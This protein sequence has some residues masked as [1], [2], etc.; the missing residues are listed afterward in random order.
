MEINRFVVTLVTLAVVPTGLDAASPAPLWDRL[1]P[2]PHAVGFRVLWKYDYARTWTSTHDGE[3]QPTAD[4]PYRPVRISIWY[5]AKIPGHASPM[6]FSGYVNVPVENRS[7]A[8]LNQRLKEYDLGGNGKGLRG[9][10]KSP[11]LLEALLDTPT[12]AFLNAPADSGSFPLVVYSLG[13]NDYTQENV[14]LWEYLASHG[15]VVATV[16][17]LGTSPRR[18]HLFIDD[19]RSY[20][21]QI[22]DL[23]FL[24][25]VLRD[26]PFVDKNKVAAAGHSMGG[27]YATLLAM[28]N[29]TIRAVISLD[30]S[31]TIKQSPYAYK[32][33]QGPYWDAARFKVPLL[34]M[35]KP[36]DLSM[37]L[38]DSLTYSDRCL[39]KLPAGVHAD[40]SSYPMYTRRADPAEL[41]PY[42]LKFRNQET[43]AIG[44]QV[45]CR[46]VLSF[47]NAHLKAE[48]TAARFLSNPPDSAEIPRGMVEH[49]FREGLKAPTEEEFCILL[50]QEGFERT[51]ARFRQLKEKYPQQTLVR[52]KVLNRIGYELIW[53]GR[54]ERSMDVFRLNAEAH[55]QSADAHD[56]LAE[57]YLVNGKKDQAIRSYR[58]SVELNPG[59][60]NALEKLKEL[61]KK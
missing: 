32:Y 2:G 46:Y 56:S 13:Q 16:P 21:A 26:M 48:A 20:E 1:Q 19:P 12:A 34:H 50:E 58:R 9:L 43:A 45:V 49:E 47:L 17:H 51:L 27:V 39:V 14:V 24:T 18:F 22:R 4:A 38:L 44:H 25:T 8:D 28:R 30:G 42:A 33:G 40:F 31:L 15:Y 3:G 59:N 52:E 10:F 7:F 60:K 11:A 35:Y 61:E 29:S 54:P 36:A 57:G 6:P 37:D 55:P 23:E 53:D 41:D 5:P